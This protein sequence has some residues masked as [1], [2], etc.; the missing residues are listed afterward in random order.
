MSVKQLHALKVGSHMISPIVSIA[1]IVCKYWDD[2]RRSRRL[3]A[4]EGTHMIVPGMSKDLRKTI[5]LA[6]DPTQWQPSMVEYNSWPPIF[7]VIAVLRRRRERE[8]RAIK[9]GQ[10]KRL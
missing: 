2:R 10:S 4:I 5:H 3:E 9:Q 8:A 7:S 6:L 1:S